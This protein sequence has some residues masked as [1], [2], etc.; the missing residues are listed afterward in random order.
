MPLSWSEIKENWI[1]DFRIAYSRRS[2]ETAFN[3]IISQWDQGFLENY[4]NKT[5]WRIVSLIDTGLL[6]YELSK[7][8]DSQVLI[9]RLRKGDR[10]AYSEARIATHFF[11][12][13]YEVRLQPIVDGTS[14]LNDVAVKVDSE[15]V[16]IE[17]KT[18]QRSYLQ[19]ELEKTLHELFQLVNRIPISRDVHLFLTKEPTYEEQKAI[20]TKAIELAI[21]DRQPSF[22]D[23]NQIAYIRNDITSS[24]PTII[25]TRMIGSL[26]IVPSYPE[27]IRAIYEEM[28]VLFS[29]GVK[30][31]TSENGINIQLTIHV[32]FEDHRIISLIEQKRRQL[33]PDSMNMV[34]LDTAHIPIK[35]HTSGYNRWI[36]RLEEAFRTKLSR[37]IGAVL[38]FSMAIDISRVDLKSSL[39][40]N[41][42]PYKRLP[43]RFLKKCD[44]NSY[45]EYR[46][47]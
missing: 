13:G 10:A 44:L 33:S 12:Q 47:Q 46:E 3:T 14:R 39:Y 40:V 32:P 22:G 17:V 11:H 24:K 6:L 1:K 37:R 21:R 25:G 43:L 34:A 45:A 16:N 27:P 8:E 18:P 28:P 9:A 29:S 7:I 30:F 31:D 15:W 42:D 2:I 26:T 4:K 19:K 5:S 36:K 35:H 20:E 38:F 23:V 41:P